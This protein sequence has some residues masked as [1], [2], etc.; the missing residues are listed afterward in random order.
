[1]TGIMA[2]STSSSS[3]ALPG[4]VWVLS[5]G[6]GRNGT[7]W[8]LLFRRRRQAQP[9]ECIPEWGSALGQGQGAMK[10]TL[11]SHGCQQAPAVAPTAGSGTPESPG[12]A[13]SPLSHSSP[14]LT[15]HGCLHSHGQQ[16]WHHC[17]VKVPAALSILLA[18]QGHT[19][20]A[21]A[22]RDH[23]LGVLGLSPC[24]AQPPPSQTAS[25]PCPLICTR[26]L[27]QCSSSDSHSTSGIHSPGV[28]SLYHCHSS[29]L[30]AITSNRGS[31]CPDMLCGAACRSSITFLH[32]LEML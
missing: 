25:T 28:D 6:S 27:G 26:I 14:A 11:D 32:V 10:P 22:H 5:A 31:S 8:S 30:P 18:L 7:C 12:V 24:R 19:V 23:V 16:A 21:L 29:S 9:P 13:C 3:S 17:L 20:Q 1:M 2:A 15:W 4:S